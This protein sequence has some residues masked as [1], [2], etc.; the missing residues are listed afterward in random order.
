MAVLK[1]CILWDELSVSM[2]NQLLQ[3]PESHM[4]VNQERMWDAPPSEGTNEFKCAMNISWTQKPLKIYFLEV[5]KSAIRSDLLQRN[6][7]YLS[8]SSLDRTDTL[9]RI[10]EDLDDLEKCQSVAQKEWVSR[11]SSINC[12]VYRPCDRKNRSFYHAQ[13]YH[14]SAGWNSLLPFSTGVA[15]QGPQRLEDGGKCDVRIADLLPALYNSSYRTL[16]AET[17]A[18]IALGFST[19]CLPQIHEETDWMSTG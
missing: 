11:L 6:V 5:L 1:Y 14:S 15:V 12:Q 4:T 9:I 2:P 19:C 10:F 3:N 16:L 8:Q 7:E 18:L 13:I 17:N